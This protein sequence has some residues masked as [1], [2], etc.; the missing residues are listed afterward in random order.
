MRGVVELLIQYE[1]NLSAVSHNETITRPSVID[2][3][4]YEHANIN[5]FIVGGWWQRATKTYMYNVLW[6]STKREVSCV[7]YQAWLVMKHMA[8]VGGAFDPTHESDMYCIIMQVPKCV[9]FVCELQ[10]LFTLLLESNQR[11]INPKPAIDVR[12]PSVHLCG[13][14]LLFSLL[15]LLLL[16]P[17]STTPQLLRSVFVQG[18]STQQEDVS[19]FTHKLLEWIEDAFTISLPTDQ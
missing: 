3:L 2:H 6:V 9:E 13:I 8:Y 16:P 5:Q 4:R 7:Q 10:K 18:P 15:L 1:V 19:E 14:R 11:Y 12:K 17:C